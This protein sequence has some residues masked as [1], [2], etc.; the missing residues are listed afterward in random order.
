LSALV[1]LYVGEKVT[2]FLTPTETKKKDETKLKVILSIRGCK[3]ELVK[4]KKDLQNATLTAKKVKEKKI[5]K[6]KK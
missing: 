2:I 1:R 4:T 3:D 6:K 5:A